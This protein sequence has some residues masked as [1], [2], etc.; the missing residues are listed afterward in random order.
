MGSF[1]QKCIKVLDF[2]TR[3][4]LQELSGHSG[5]VMSLKFHRNILLSA[6]R[7]RTIKSAFAPDVVLW[8]SIHAF[9]FIFTILSVVRLHK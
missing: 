3:K 1:D 4:T 8:P 2:H 9:S 6:S 5:G 7:D